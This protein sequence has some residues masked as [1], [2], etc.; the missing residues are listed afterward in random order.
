MELIKLPP[1]RIA[2]GSKWVKKKKKDADGNLERC[3]ARLVAQGYNQKCGEHYDETTLVVRLKSVRTFI[4]L[5]VKNGLYLHQ[6]DIGTAFLNGELKET[7]YK[8]TRR[9]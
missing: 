6:L 1:D 8:A 2:V 4:E 3:K 7:M 5:A 9:I